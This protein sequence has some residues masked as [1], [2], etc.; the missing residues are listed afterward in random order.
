MPEPVREGR[1]T[2][3]SERSR[4]AFLCLV[5]AARRYGGDDAAMKKTVWAF[6]AALATLLAPAPLGARAA[7]ESYPQNYKTEVRALK[8]PVPGLKLEPAGGDR[9]LVLRN[10]TG[11]V[12]IVTGYDGDPYLRFRPDRVVEVNVHSPSKYVNE[13]RFGTLQPPSSARPGATP[14]W[15]LVATNGSYKW[16]DHR[17]H[18]MEKTIPQQVKDRDKRTKIFDWDVPLEVNGRPVQAAG[19]LMWVPDSSSS[20][21]STGVVAAIAA[22]AV[23]ALA[24]ILLLLRRRSR[25]ATDRPPEKAKEAW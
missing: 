23:L 6:L 1:S 14:K 21:I 12:V 20:G 22:A 16:F 3:A 5:G 2:G 25:P 19:T 7:D 15:K 17:T 11:K 9:Y 18:W 8:P 13:D 10:G 24:V 4:E